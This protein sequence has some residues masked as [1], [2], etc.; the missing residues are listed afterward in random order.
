MT[1]CSLGAQAEISTSASERVR[2]KRLIRFLFSAMITSIIDNNKHMLFIR[3]NVF[4]L[5]LAMDKAIDFSTYQGTEDIPSPFVDYSIPGVI[6]GTY[7]FIY[8]GIG[9][10]SAK[11]GTFICVIDPRGRTVYGQRVIGD[12]NNI[13]SRFPSAG[14]VRRKG[15]GGGKTAEGWSGYFILA[16]PQGGQNFDSLQVRFENSEIANAFLN[17]CNTIFGTQF[18]IR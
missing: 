9:F 17:A 18:T 8:A 5:Q 3:P 7:S 11:D 1:F 14:P 2:E 12:Q 10:N 15:I 6:P 4:N 13:I 16:K